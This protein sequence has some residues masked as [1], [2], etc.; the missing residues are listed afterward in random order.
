MW[1]RVTNYIEWVNDTNQDALAVSGNSLVW[2]GINTE[3]LSGVTYWT[4]GTVTYNASIANVWRNTYDT[5]PSTFTT[6]NASSG[7]ANAEIAGEGAGSG[8]TF[9]IP[10]TAAKSGPSGTDSTSAYVLAESPASN[11]IPG[12]TGYLLGYQLIADC[13]VTHPFKNPITN[14]GSSNTGPLLV[15]DVTETSTAQA[16]QFE[17][18]GYRLTSGSYV[19]QAD[20]AASSWASYLSCVGQNGLQLY[21]TKLYYPTK[22]LN[23]GDYSWVGDGNPEASGQDYSGASG[24]LTYYR[25]FTCDDAT[26]HG[27]KYELSG[28]GT[29]TGAETV[30]AGSDDNFRLFF[31]VPN[32]HDEMVTDWLDAAQD[33]TWDETIDEVNRNGRMGGSVAAQDLEIGVSTVNYISWGT[34]SLG[35]VTHKIVAKIETTTGW[36]GNL[37]EMFCTF[38]NSGGTGLAPAMAPDLASSA[39]GASTPLNGASGAECKL[40]F[41]GGSAIATYTNVANTAGYTDQVDENGLYEKELGPD[42]NGAW[43]W[44]AY[45]WDNAAVPVIQV[46]INGEVDAATGFPAGSFGRAITLDDESSNRLDL[47]I[48]GAGT[49]DHTV[50]L[51][52]AAAI[53]DTFN[54]QG[55]GFSDISSAA[56]AIYGGN[57]VPDYT[58]M[59]RNARFRIGSQDMRN[60]WNYARVVHVIAG[61]SSPGDINLRICR[62]GV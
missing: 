48:N 45:Q 28:V 12:T 5:N 51:D 62:V 50:D 21:A 43:R 61:G 13:T 52:G 22:T 53:S 42:S 19:N 38:T 54:A 16:E 2:S 18:E 7:Y 11:F 60:G 36:T 57:D 58:K 59:W 1:K 25:E 37:S 23:G 6:S 35:A 26:S 41:G 47:Y 8:W 9:T 20:I 32:Q 27:F 15:Y 34:G 14:G 46:Q 40:S 49:P 44:G 3:S 55:S 4:E 17:G 24:L 10:A 31:R 29:L 39:A 56:P 30:L 33:F